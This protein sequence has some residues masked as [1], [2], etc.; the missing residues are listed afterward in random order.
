[1]YRLFVTFVYL[2][3]LSIKFSPFVYSDDSVLVLQNCLDNLERLNVIEYEETASVKENWTKTP[4]GGLLSK[5]VISHVRRD[6]DSIDVEHQEKIFLNGKFDHLQARRDIVLADSAIW[7]IKDHTVSQNF[8]EKNVYTGAI[9]TEA[10][11]RRLLIPVLCNENSGFVL[12]GYFDEFRFPKL[13]LDSGHI[14]NFGEE[15]IGN[16][17]C[18]H[19]QAKTL[20]GD[21]SVW[22]DQKNGHVIRKAISTKNKEN[23]KDFTSDFPGWI[24]YVDVIEDIDYKCIDGVYIPVTGKR[25]TTQK[26]ES[27]IDS[28]TTAL[29]ARKNIL[30]SPV[31]KG[32]NAFV[33]DFPKGERVGNIDDKDSGVVYLWNGKKATAGYTALEGTA[34]FKGTGNVV[35]IL[36]MLSGVVMMSVWAFFKIRQIVN[37]ALK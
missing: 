37:K 33:S 13:M 16:Y 18:V 32:T 17:P 28:V 10:N 3:V 23:A 7:Q 25:T 21:I 1:M 4:P 22:I 24:S 27:G 20:K 36:L 12:D 11:R 6:G 34:Y 9:V 29:Y 5:E 14:Q 19:L 26:R 15:L 31:F 2:I 8:N 35:R 30:L